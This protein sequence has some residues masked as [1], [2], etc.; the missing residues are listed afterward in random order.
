MVFIKGKQYEDSEI[1]AAM[2]MYDEIKSRNPALISKMTDL[3]DHGQ[4]VLA[5]PCPG[6]YIAAYKEPDDSYGGLFIDYMQN[7]EIAE[8]EE[9]LYGHPISTVESPFS[10]KI[11]SDMESG[12]RVTL[13]E[14]MD[15][16]KVTRTIHI[17]KQEDIAFSA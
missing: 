14:D 11:T 16:E 10:D 17:R 13:Y 15:G 2:Q 3:Q 6:G 12:I 9:Y 4:I 7:D 5:Q 1:I 8:D